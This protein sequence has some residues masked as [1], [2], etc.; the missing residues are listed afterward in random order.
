[1]YVVGFSKK[2]EDMT[3]Y[4]ETLHLG[5]VKKVQKEHHTQNTMCVV[6]LCLYIVTV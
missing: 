4:I 1:M 3:I 6:C 5:H 2:K